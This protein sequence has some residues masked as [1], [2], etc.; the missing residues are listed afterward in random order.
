MFPQPFVEEY[1]LPE[2]YA[3]SIN[4]HPTF[5]KKHN[6]FITLL[7]LLG[8][9]CADNTSFRNVGSH[10]TQATV[11]LRHF[12]ILNKGKLYLFSVLLAVHRDISVQ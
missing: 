6:I 10:K 11:S 12:C 1:I 8:R 5:R 4:T 2:C 9:E 7:G 3:V